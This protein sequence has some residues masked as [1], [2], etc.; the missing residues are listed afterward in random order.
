[1]T[2]GRF[3]ALLGRKGAPS[4]RRRATLTVGTVTAVVVLAFGVVSWQL[5]ASSLRSAVDSDL[6]GVVSALESAGVG[7]LGSAASQD[8]RFDTLEGLPDDGDRPPLPFVEVFDGDGAVVFGDLP[9]TESSIAVAVGERGATFE[10]LEVGDRSIRTLTVPAEQAAGGGALRVG[11]DV[12]NVVDGLRR[13]RTGTALAGLVAGLVAAAIAWLVGGRLIAPV[14]AVA[15]AADHLRRHDELPDR[16]EGEG[17]DELG[18]LV[19]SFNALLDD[20][21]ASREGQRRLVADASHELRTPLT[22]LRVKTEFIQ[23]S[24][25]LPVDER[26]RLLD[27]AVVDLEALTEL[28]SELVELASDGANPERA[29]LI[30]LAQ[31]VE[32]TVE[33]FEITTGRHVEVTT[34]TGLVETRPRQVQRALA[35]LL[36]NADKYS[37]SDGLIEVAQDGPR[38]A[39]RDHGPGIPAGERE[40]VF[41]RFYRGPSHQSVE[42]SGL[43]LAIVESAATSNG[44]TTW[45]GDPVDGG[46][47]VVVG[48]SVG[49][50]PAARGGAAPPGTLGG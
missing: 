7:D 5:I 36:I 13:A 23:S 48:F 28:V 32:V 44:G 1:M 21:R 17:D 33:H 14:T 4:M 34:S 6:R 18:Q 45:V 49:P 20:L 42:G 41:D 46:P 43:G 9:R 38:I 27:G 37:P 16:L 31:L 29:R 47:G 10:T 19:R 35:N 40:R 11:I 26:Q 2:T 22:S 30:D 3:R 50:I 39:V 24:P 15:A 8:D 12:T 25:D